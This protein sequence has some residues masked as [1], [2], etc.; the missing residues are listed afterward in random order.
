MSYYCIDIA[1]IVTLDGHPKWFPVPLNAPWV[2][3][4]S[5]ERLSEQGAIWDKGLTGSAGVLYIDLVDEVGP[6]ASGGQA[7][8]KEVDL[9]SMSGF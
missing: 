7:D 3:V 1:V 5:S 2:L 6:Q 4:I 9:D 8:L